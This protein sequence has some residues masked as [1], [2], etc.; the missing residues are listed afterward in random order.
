M[1]VPTTALVTGASRGFGRAIAAALVAAGSEV[2]GIARS[3]QD[4]DAVRD[5]LGERFVPVAADVTDE[6]V[7]ASLIADRKPGL[8]VLNAGVSPHLAPLADQTWETF[9]GPWDVDVRQAFAWMRA[10]LRVP[11][12]P[13]GVV[14]G[15]SS[16]AALAGSPLSGG[17]AGAKATIRFLR[18]YA[19]DE[20][21][22]AG[23]DLRFHAL[24]PQ[25]TPRTGLGALAVAGYA[26]RHGVDPDTLAANLAPVLTPEQVADTVLAVAADD[27]AAAEYRISG[28]GAS[29]LG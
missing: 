2:V 18:T 13:G 17:Y 19:H 15:M 25:L 23:L 14:V 7:A 3:P 5:D 1:P 26:A 29:V 8:L 21:Q 4:L 16:G 20:A 10:A 22:R 28:A 11:M 27:G 6:D 9:R 24:L 12:A